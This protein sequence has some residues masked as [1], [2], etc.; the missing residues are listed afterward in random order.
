MQKS[1]IGIVPWIVFFIALVLLVSH[2]LSWTQITIDG[3]TLVLLGILLVCAFFGRIRKFKWGEFEA[4]IA[5]DEVKKIVNEA[6]KYIGLQETRDTSAPETRTFA[7]ELR[8]LLN[9]DHVLALAKLR[10]DLES[11][12]KRLYAFSMPALR[13]NQK[14]INLFK[15]AVILKESGIVPDQIFNTLQEVILL[16][17]R[18]VH[19]EYIR[20]DDAKSIINVGIRI[21]EQLILETEEFITR[22]IE[23][24]IISQ[25]EVQEF[26]DAKYRVETITPYVENPERSV[27]ILDQEGMDVLLEGYN[28]YAEFIVNVEKTDAKES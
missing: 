12:L 16:C 2:S 26:R 20:P 24:K 5:P 7:D 18:A 15:M 9:K 4:E 11:T 21:L 1:K 19:G 3:T 28:E 25:N 22:P 27:R 6:D 14:Q 17:N 23:T 13:K 10:M 8:D